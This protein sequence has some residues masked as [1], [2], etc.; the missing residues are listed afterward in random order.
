MKNDFDKIVSGIA[1][2][3]QSYRHL[4]ETYFRLNYRC[5]SLCLAPLKPKR[6]TVLN[7][8]VFMPKYGQLIFSMQSHVSAR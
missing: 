8:P 4:K 2:R 3:I 5:D 7:F 6:I 1:G